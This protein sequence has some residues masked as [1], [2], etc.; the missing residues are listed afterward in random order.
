MAPFSQTP[1]S[2][3]TRVLVI[4]DDRKLCRLIKE[5]LEPLGYEISAVHDGIAGAEKAVA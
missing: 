1:D 3:K 2:R 5:Y 4:D